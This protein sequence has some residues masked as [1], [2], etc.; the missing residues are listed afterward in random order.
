MLAVLFLRGVVLGTPNPGMLVGWPPQADGR[1]CLPI[2]NAFEQLQARSLKAFALDRGPHPLEEF[3][4]RVVE[5]PLPT[6]EAFHRL[7]RVNSRCFL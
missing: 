2:P 3:S 4:P 6:Q 1:G 7:A 5:N